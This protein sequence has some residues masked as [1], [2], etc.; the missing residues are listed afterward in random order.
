MIPFEIIKLDKPRKIRFN[1]SKQIEVEKT[2]GKKIHELVEDI[3]LET[4]TEILLIGLRDGSEQL[5]KQEL[6]KIL[7]GYAES[8]NYVVDC[9]SK[10]LI[11]AT[12]GEKGRKLL[13]E[14][15]KL[16]GAENSETE[17][18]HGMDGTGENSENLQQK[19]E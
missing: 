10:A 18:K 4:A 16:A 11:L 1:I 7:D 14:L 13:E 9:V 12:S 6:I 5:T 2:T 8:S 15:D 3:G 17:K 19:Q